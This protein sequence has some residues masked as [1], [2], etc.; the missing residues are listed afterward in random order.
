M[1][2]PTCETVQRFISA[3]PNLMS[4]PKPL[5]VDPVLQADRERKAIN[6]A[7]SRLKPGD[8]I[9]YADQDSG[10]VIQVTV[11]SK[12]YANGAHEAIGTDGGHY[13]MRWVRKRKESA[14]KLLCQ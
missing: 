4:Y 8:V 3:N 10:A 14:F 9:Y 13:S 6:V 1:S 2:Y 7:Y 12:R 11:A 5:E